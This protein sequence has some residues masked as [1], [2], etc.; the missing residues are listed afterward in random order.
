MLCFHGSAKECATI[1]DEA[2]LWPISKASCL[3]TA[4]RSL[5]LGHMLSIGPGRH[6]C[7][8]F[9]EVTKPRVVGKPKRGGNFFHGL[10]GF[11]KSC[12]GLGNHAFVHQGCGGPR[13]VTFADT[14]EPVVLDP[15]SFAVVRNFPMI[16]IVQ[17]NEMPKPPQD[18]GA[19]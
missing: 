14:V 3:D 10:P 2:G 17:F 4:V 9:K 1:V 15:Q 13:R 12:L 18:L 19:F 8:S 11:F 6:T 5:S 16:A 7:V